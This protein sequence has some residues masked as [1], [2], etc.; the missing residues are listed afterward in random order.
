MLPETT[1]STQ[2]FPHSVVSGSVLN[3]QN[4]VLRRGIVPVKRHLVYTSLLTQNTA[5]TD[6]S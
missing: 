4:D 5:Q 1:A 3:V 6:Y 2:A